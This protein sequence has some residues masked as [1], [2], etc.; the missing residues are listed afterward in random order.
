[1]YTDIIPQI[2][3]EI[4]IEQ[5]W[6]RTYTKQKRLLILKRIDVWNP[7]VIVISEINLSDCIKCKNSV[8][9]LCIHVDAL[10]WAY[11]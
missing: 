4:R 5:V 7:R 6:A 1:M 10:K 11:V 2:N 9:I 3:K 8:Q